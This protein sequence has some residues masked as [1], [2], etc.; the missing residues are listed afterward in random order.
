MA[1]ASGF[2]YPESTAKLEALLVVV[3]DE[4]RPL[5]A[6]G[7]KRI[8]ELYLW[9]G[10]LPPLVTIHGLRLLHEAMS[11]E[12]KRLGYDEVN[13]FLPPSIC[14]KFARRLEKT[15]GWKPNW[16]GWTRGL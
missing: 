3:D 8:C 10:K 6:V 11:R 13:A 7:A 16:P 15:F 14:K 1:K 5:M 4:D 9:C 2:P 12:L